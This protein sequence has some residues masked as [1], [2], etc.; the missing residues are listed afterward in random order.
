MIPL[1]PVCHWWIGWMGYWYVE[2]M[3]SC[4]LQI[5]TPH[6]NRQGPGQCDILVVGQIVMVRRDSVICGSINSIYVPETIWGIPKPRG[7]NSVAQL[8][9]TAYLCLVLPLMW[10][11]IK[12]T[13][14]QIKPV[15]ISGSWGNSRWLRLK[16]HLDMIPNLCL[17]RESV[18]RWHNLELTSER[19]RCTAT[20]PWVDLNSHQ[21][22]H[23]LCSVS[24]TC[25]HGHPCT[26]VRLKPSQTNWSLLIWK[27]TEGMTRSLRHLHMEYNLWVT[28]TELLHQ[29]ACIGITLWSYSCL[30]ASVGRVTQPDWS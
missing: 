9:R 30:L 11:E 18:L 16:L 22:Q 7:W 27:C 28:I 21:R 8:G 2:L 10:D 23:Y 3:D 6:E 1:L 14:T 19:L 29:G 17:F 24:C 5:W 20:P 12:L 15:S 13:S 25:W 26:T 4:I